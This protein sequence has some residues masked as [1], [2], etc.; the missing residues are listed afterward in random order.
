M[1]TVIGML[2]F[3]ASIWGQAGPVQR[4][5]YEWANRGPGTKTS[6]TS[7][8]RPGFARR[9]NVNFGFRHPVVEALGELRHKLPAAGILGSRGIAYLQQIEADY[10][11]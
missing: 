6:R 2:P 10:Q 9:Y 4:T 5:A 1:R 11:H 3:C 7:G 8:C